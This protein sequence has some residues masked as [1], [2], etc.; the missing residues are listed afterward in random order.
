MPHPR[1][2]STNGEEPLSE[3]QERVLAA[4][5]RVCERQ[6]E[7]LAPEME[8]VADLGIDS[9]DGLLLLIELEEILGLEISDDDAEKMNTVA[10]VLELVAATA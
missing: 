6:P 8:L 2:G 3:A 1:V 7:D 4:I 9:A 10:D 5:A